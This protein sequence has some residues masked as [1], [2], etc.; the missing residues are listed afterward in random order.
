MG[1][2]ADPILLSVLMEI[3]DE[4]GDLK[5]GQVALRRAVEALDGK[6][7]AIGRRVEELGARVA[8]PDAK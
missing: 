5:A 8:R 6:A 1:A 3:R 4:I 2:D 7:E